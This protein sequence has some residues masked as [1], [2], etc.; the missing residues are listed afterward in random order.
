MEIKDI[1][2]LTRNLILDGETGKA[3]ETILAYLRQYNA[4]PDI[5]RILE[6]QSANYNATRQQEQKNIL[7]FQEA[8]R[9]YSQVNDVILE[10]LDHLEGGKSPAAVKA[11]NNKVVYWWAGEA[12][13]QVKL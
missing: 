1:T 13:S 5:R 9:L 4:A 10:Q 2:T 7:S 12:V 6:V 8:Q 11:G 3:L